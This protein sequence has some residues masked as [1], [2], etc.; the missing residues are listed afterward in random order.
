M[1]NFY[2]NMRL[3]VR[4]RNDEQLQGKKLGMVEDCQPFKCLNDTKKHP[5]APCGAVA[6]SFFNGI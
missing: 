3:Y 1:N 6:N 5:F 4:S 2:Q